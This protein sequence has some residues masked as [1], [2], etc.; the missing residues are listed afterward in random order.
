MQPN[1]NVIVDTICRTAKL[2]AIRSKTDLLDRFG[3][4]L[5]KNLDRQDGD[6]KSIGTD[7]K[8]PARHMGR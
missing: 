2:D 5:R 4:T 3:D 1:G 8:G 7:R 6:G